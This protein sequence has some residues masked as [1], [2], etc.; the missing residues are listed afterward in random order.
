VQ[1]IPLT[2][3]QIAKLK[4]R[5]QASTLAASHP[6]A[7]KQKFGREHE[8]IESLAMREVGA[9]DGDKLRVI[10]AALYWAEGGKYRNAVAFVNSDPQMI[11]LMMKFFREVCDVKEEK[12]RGMLHIHPHLDGEGALGF[13][14]SITG[15]PSSQFYKTQRAVS[16]ASIHHEQID[17]RKVL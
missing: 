11:R 17:C 5:E 4:G 14:S 7:P 9:I 1:D 3:A 2:A 15:I 6:N 16:K 10:G 12:F 8:Q 13:W